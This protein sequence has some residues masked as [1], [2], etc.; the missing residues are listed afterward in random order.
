MA[1]RDH[2]GITINQFNGLWDQGNPL[3][4]PRDHFWDG[5]NVRFDGNNSIASRN[6]V[7]IYEQTASPLGNVVRVYNYITQTANTLLCLVWDGVN[8]SIYHVTGPTTVLGPVLTVAGMSDFGFAAYAGRAY[9]SPFGS[10]AV[11]DLYVEKGLQNE[12]VYVYRGDGTAATPAAGDAPSGTVTVANGAAGNTDAGQHLFGV[13]YETDTGYLS[14]PAAF[15]SF[16]TSASLSVS[17]STIPVSPASNVVRRHIV[18]TKVIPT[19]TYNGNL[20]GY[21]YFFIPNAVVNDN[22]TTTLSN[23]SFFDADLLEDASYL[24]DNFDEIPAGAG[25]NFYGNRLCV[26]ATFD[27]I[28]LCYVSAAGEPEAISQLDGFITAPLDGN[29]ITYVQELRDILYVFKRN[30][31]FGFAGDVDA[32][33]A[34]WAMTVI[35]Q[36]L[37]C[38][39]HGI[40]TVLDSGGASVDYLLVASYSGLTIFNGRYAPMELTWKINS[41]WLNQNRVFFNRIQVVHDSINKSLYIVLP[42]RRILVGDYRNGL[43][44]KNI[45]WAPWRFEFEV[46]SIALV[47]IDDIIIASAGRLNQAGL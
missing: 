32:A 36:A 39:I 30:R 37:G 15:R 9:L 38:P 28:S 31:T 44:P 35:D 46:N 20:T 13:V 43:D 27:D 42:D 19:G 1:L 2:Q 29:P 6:G 12:V 25:L 41:F 33:P 23:I 24:L 47:N 8:G 5:E 34:E 10:F 16:T 11:G 22:V 14:P 26:W 4:T 21:Q 40:A 18:A 3:N 17:F 7:D 45:R